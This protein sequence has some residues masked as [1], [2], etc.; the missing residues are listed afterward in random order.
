[1]FSWIP[2][3]TE[4][5]TKILP[6]RNRQSELIQLLK[7]LGAEGIPAGSTFDKDDKGAK[8]PLTSID[9]FTFYTCFNRGRMIGDPGRD[10]T[11]RDTPRTDPDGRSLAHPVLISDEWRRSVHQE[12][13][14]AHAVEEAIAEPK[15]ECVSKRSGLSGSDDE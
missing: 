13:D 15:R 12:R 5:A 2:M 8:I 11:V 1:M 10:I 6:F 14:G 7:Q 4:L 9:P 3:Y